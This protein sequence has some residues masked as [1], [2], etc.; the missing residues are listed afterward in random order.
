MPAKPKLIVFDVNETLL[1]L[2]PLKSGV[3]QSL[4]NGMAFDLWFGNLLHYSLV[5]TVTEQYSDFSAIAEATF[6]MVA[7][8]FKIN[9]SKAEIG[10]ILAIITDLPP[11]SD[12]IQA[13]TLLEDAGF[14]M[15]ALTN[16]NQEVAEKQ[17]TNAGIHTFLKDI[18]SVEHA[19]RYKPH[20]DAYHFL[21]GK[22]KISA[23]DAMLVAAHGWDIVGAQ[24]AG[25]RTAFVAREG[26]FLYP[27]GNNPDV[28]GK[29]LIEVAERLARP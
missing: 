6:Q 28:T 19:E 7:Q 18:I 14:T 16:G 15:A 24:R 9:I 27:L 17:L 5:E 1:N 11:H 13:L 26:K 12:V 21:L 3:N 2:N 29:T 4:G 25:M 10:S 8:K 23:K 20:A 22:M